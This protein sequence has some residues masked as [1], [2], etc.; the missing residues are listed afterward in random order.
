MKLTKHIITTRTDREMSDLELV[1]L[2]EQ[3]A[4]EV[5]LSLDAVVEH[6]RAK[7]PGVFIDWEN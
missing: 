3:I 7:F 5:A 2:S 1:T 6:L 4:D